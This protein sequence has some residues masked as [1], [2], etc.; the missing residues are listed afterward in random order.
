M[1]GIT[2]V[3]DVNASGF[4]SAKAVLSANTANKYSGV[5][6]ISEVTGRRDNLRI[7]RGAITS[8]E[9][10]GT[11][12]ATANRGIGYLDEYVDIPDVRRRGLPLRGVGNRAVKYVRPITRFTGGVALSAYGSS[13]G[14][15]YGDAYTGIE[16]YIQEGRDQAFQN[17]A[18]STYFPGLHTHQDG[19]RDDAAYPWG[20]IGYS[21]TRVIGATASSS[22]FGWSVDASNKTEM[23]GDL[24]YQAGE[25]MGWSLMASGGWAW[26]A[27]GGNS[28]ITQDVSGGSWI[29]NKFAVIASTQNDASVPTSGQRFDD[30]ATSAQWTSALSTTAAATYVTSLADGTGRAIRV[31]MPD[32]ASASNRVYNDT[33][34]YTF[35]TRATG[36]S[37]PAAQLF[38]GLTLNHAGILSLSQQ[39]SVE[40]CLIRM[41]VARAMGDRRAGISASAD[42]SQDHVSACVIE[43][44]HQGIYPA[45]DPGKTQLSAAPAYGRTI[46]RDSKIQFIAELEY[47]QDTDGHAWGGQGTGGGLIMTGSSVKNT[48]GALHHYMFERTPLAVSGLH[49]ENTNISGKSAFGGGLTDSSNFAIQRGGDFAQDFLREVSAVVRN[50]K[51]DGFLVGVRD[52]WQDGLR[53]CASRIG[54]TNFAIRQ[55]AANHV[56]EGQVGSMLVVAECTL[57]GSAAYGFNGATSANR[58]GINFSNNHIIQTRAT[59]ADGSFTGSQILADWQAN[60]ASGNLSALVC[61][62]FDENTIVTAS[63]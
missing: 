45:L 8:A 20:N 26:A 31:I 30:I 57:V 42:V 39:T 12:L 47:H 58:M 1:S 54:G 63:E 53:V 34:G 35:A 23:R 49:I 27:D 2:F 50:V 44:C 5:V 13:T 40:D 37:L 55:L 62:R 41:H 61:A 22:D 6:R 60:T 9:R 15:T 18:V 21:R 52:K 29:S 10:V 16:Q 48:G 14:D 59:V 24:P 3:L 4:A 33:E 19:G 11:I 43:W 32:Q 56:T 51:T 36:E 38:R 46:V 25:I 28:W 17:S 7:V